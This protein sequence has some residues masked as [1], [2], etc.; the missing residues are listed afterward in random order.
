M[1]PLYSNTHTHTHTQ[2]N[3]RKRRKE[4]A[5]IGRNKSSETKHVGEEHFNCWV[6]HVSTWPLPSG[7][8]PAAFP[9]RTNFLPKALEKH[10][11]Y[12]QSEGNCWPRAFLSPGPNLL[13]LTRV[14]DTEVLSSAAVLLALGSEVGPHW[15]VITGSEDDAE[16]LLSRP[17][18]DRLE[19]ERSQS[20]SGPSLVSPALHTNEARW[21]SGHRPT[22]HQRGYTRPPMHPYRHSHSSCTNL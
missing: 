21:Y 5:L 2:T 16:D 18:G 1:R 11:I 9:W 7:E 19:E 3:N 22:R 12:W 14:I 4:F 6:G 15:I 17:Q 20:I 10:G 13:S 8:T